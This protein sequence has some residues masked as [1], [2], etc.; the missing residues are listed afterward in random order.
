MKIELHNFPLDFLP[1][2][3]PQLPSRKPHFQF[4]CLFHFDYWYH[5]ILHT[6]VCMH[7]YAQ[8]YISTTF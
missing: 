6:Y 3:L 2:N 5:N 7:W 1:Y 8:I 4:D